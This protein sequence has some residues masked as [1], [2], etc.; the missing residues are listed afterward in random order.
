MRVNR[1]GS[2]GFGDAVRN[3]FTDLVADIPAEK[4]TERS[5]G[6]PI[7]LLCGVIDLHRI[8]QVTP[9][10]ELTG[11]SLSYPTIDTTALADRLSTE[12][13]PASAGGRETLRPGL[14]R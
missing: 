1:A 6:R 8:I 9:D 13:R 14:A 3:Q 4:L 2:T 5:G 10:H 11:S 7:A 12:L